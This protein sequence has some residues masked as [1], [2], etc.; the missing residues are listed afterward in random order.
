MTRAIPRVPII[1]ACSLAFAPL[2][3]GNEIKAVIDQIRSTTLQPAR[4]VV[5]DNLEIDMGPATLRLNHGLLI[6]AAPNGDRTTELVFLGDA[7]F[8]MSPPNAIE[9]DQLELFTRQESLDEPIDRAVFVIG[10]GDLTARL[11][12]RDPATTLDPEQ[13]AAA[14]DVFRNWVEG[15]ERR[16]FG[17]DSAILKSILGESAYQ[18]YFAVWCHSEWNL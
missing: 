6:P 15:P 13:A 14:D 10:N 7:H 1:V 18:D 5:V 16:G 17:A 11:L 12:D 3:H 2:V 8:E 9:A 4:A